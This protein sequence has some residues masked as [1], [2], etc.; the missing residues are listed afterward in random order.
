MSRISI[1]LREWQTLSPANEQS[2]EG[3]TLGPDDRARDFASRLAKSG[4]IEVLELARGLEVRSTSW[5]GRIALGDATIT[6]EPKL[7]GAPLLGLLRYAYGLRDLDVLAVTE[8][9]VSPDT[10]QD[11]LIQQLIGEATELLARGLHRTYQRRREMLAS[12]RGR[13]DFAGYIAAGAAQAVLPCNHYP[14]TESIPLNQALLAGL[15]F[16]VGCTENLVLRVRLRRLVQL[17]DQDVAAAPLNRPLL[18]QAQTCLDRRT[19]GYRP[20]LTLIRLLMESSGISFDSDQNALPL[21][22]FLFDMNR[23]FQALL[24]RFLSEHLKGYVLKDEYRLRGM[25]NY[26]ALHN[27]RQRRSPTPRPDF[28]VLEGGRVVALLDAKYRDLWEHTLPRE[29]LYQ[30]ALYALSQAAVRDA[31]ILYPTTE[32]SAVDQVVVLSEPVGGASRARVVLRP[33]KLLE[34]EQMLRL[35]A[36]SASQVHRE[37]A[38]RALVFGGE[39]GSGLPGSHNAGCT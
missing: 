20:A 32:S 6:V 9:D 35:P 36:G 1:R 12:P 8:Y 5:V 33:V 13:I 31:V 4:R 34:L 14:R 24:S 15:R 10:F 28:A 39:Q 19:R 21:P 22:G 17:M 25:F 23:F 30:L 26:D 2:L 29:M 11:L 3:C 7:T 38:A 16:A 37:Q 27:P 18:Q